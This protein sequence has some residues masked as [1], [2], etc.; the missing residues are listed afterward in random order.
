MHQKQNI[1][2]NG[3]EWLEMALPKDLKHSESF[4][5]TYLSL[6]GILIFAGIEI[7]MGPAFYLMPAP[8]N[9]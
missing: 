9:F 5:I 3:L 8:F 1:F 2:G 7:K 6:S 4:V